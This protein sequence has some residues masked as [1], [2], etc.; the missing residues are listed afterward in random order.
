[1]SNNYRFAKE[2]WVAA[3]VALIL[4]ASWSVA[5]AGGIAGTVRDAV[6]G[7]P[8]A[9]IDLDLFDAAFHAVNDLGGGS[10]AD[11]VDRTS[12]DGTY[13]LDGLVAGQYFLRADPSTAQ[14]YVSQYHPDVFLK[15]EAA[16]VAVRETGMTTVD[17]YL[18]RGHSINGRVLDAVTGLPLQNA[19]LDVF[20]WDQ[21]FLSDVSATTDADGNYTLGTLPDGEFYL[22]AENPGAMYLPQF[23]TDG[24]TLDQ[25]TPVVVQD[26]NV[27]GVD[28]ALLRGG[29]IAGQVV[30][31]FEGGF[32]PLADVDI[33]VFDLDHNLVSSVNAKTD[34]EG[35]Y[36]IGVLEPGSYY[37]KADANAESGYLDTFVGQALEIEEA[38]L[39]GVSGGVVTPNTDV[40]LLK[41][42][43]ISGLVTHADSGDPLANVQIEMFDSTGDERLETT[44]TAAD[45]SYML[46]AMPTGGYILRCGGVS[47]LGLA[48]E[49]HSDVVL[50]SEAQPIPVVAGSH[51]GGV[52][53]A[54]EP[55]G[56]ISGRVA[57]DGHGPLANVDMDLFST[58]REVISALDADTDADGRFLLG[59]IPVGTYVVRADP[60]GYEDLDRMWYGDTHR[61]A[62]ATPLTVAPGA[63]LE[64]ILFTYRIEPKRPGARAWEELAANPNPF[65][66]MTTIS[67]Q[68]PV[69]A[70][71]RVTIHDARGRVVAL[72]ADAELRAGTHRFVWDGR[73]ANGQ[74]SATG[75]HF[76]RL[77]YAD[78]VVK[79]KII[80]LK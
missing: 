54:L 49:Y 30:A 69:D 36:E 18:V 12:E 70:R 20:A 27:G 56:W 5:S 44:K 77:Q 67:F 7:E 25:A 35:R 11:P 17:F 74:P 14:G 60:T 39:V 33:D 43:T 71:A 66:P 46:G 28:F 64:E 53:F 52:D 68:L 63:T 45:G 65:N 32:G 58:E 31:E 55:G 79:R 48:F 26:D 15:S 3:A 59:P 2:S 47:E 37:L 80:L 34:D 4:T 6:T 19:D 9:N 73:L 42:A 13:T 40:L 21:S 75:V 23:W 38:E 57:I 41:G 10:G 76:V 72:L 24:A 22:R 8:L 78:Q 16:S 1:M 62:S 29:A 51:V 61:F 50:L